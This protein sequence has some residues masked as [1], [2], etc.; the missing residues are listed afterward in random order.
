MLEQRQ[1]RGEQD[2]RPIYCVGLQNILAD[3]ML[4]VGP[5]LFDEAGIV[6]RGM[7]DICPERVVPDVGD[8]VGIEGQ[9]DSPIQPG[10]GPRDAKIAQRLGQHVERLVAVALGPDEIGIALDVFEHLLA[11]LLDP[12]E[13]VALADQ[14]DGA[15]VRGADVAGQQFFFGVE[16]LAIDAVQ[17]LVIAKVDIA[18]R[19]RAPQHLLHPL[20]MDLV[21]GAHPVVVADAEPAEGLVEQRAH[22]VGVGLRL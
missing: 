21:G 14:L 22:L 3:E 4:G 6:G 20:L 1:A 10:L 18:A 15:V 12:Q 11:V 16:A 8:V 13:V 5:H 2:R 7:T 9:F 19:V 17:P